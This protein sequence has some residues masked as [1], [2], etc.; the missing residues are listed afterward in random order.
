MAIFITG[1]TGNVGRAAVAWLAEQ[2]QPVVA[3]VRNPKDLPPGYPAGAQV[4]HFDF[5]APDTFA[6]ALAGCNRLLLVRPPALANVQKDFLPFLQYAQ[7]VGVEHIVL[8]SVQGADKNSF[9][10]HAKLEKQLQ[11]M[12]FS[13]TFLRP[14]FF[15]QNITEVHLPTIQ[16]YNCIM[17]PAGRGSVPYIDARDIGAVA[18]RILQEPEGHRNAAYT[19]T[20]EEKLTFYEVAE[21]MRNV[22]QR[23]IRYRPVTFPTYYC[24]L[25]R[26]GQP[27]GFALTSTI[28][29]A[30]VWLG[31]AGEL[32]TTTRDILGRA[33]YRFAEFIAH[34]KNK[35]TFAQED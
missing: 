25:R 22:L 10:P 26:S 5:H 6:G 1:A 15:M 28:I 35:G 12:A 24:Q 34:E 14:G 13:Y 32:T 21:V 29:Y 27:K 2:Q 7:A 19:L 33:P 31:L 16:R 23:P 11:Q 17:V 3:G 4:R 20:G 9:L 8:L 30:T 18:G